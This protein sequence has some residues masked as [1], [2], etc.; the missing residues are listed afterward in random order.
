[1]TDSLRR[2]NLPEAVFICL[3][4]PC[5]S[6]RGLLPSLRAPC[7]SVRASAA[8]SRGIKVARDGAFLSPHGKFSEK[9]WYHR[10]KCDIVQ[11][12]R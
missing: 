5:G 1:M 7:G 12:E 6:V 2:V 4:A 8:F 11:K 9:L 3:R 10:K